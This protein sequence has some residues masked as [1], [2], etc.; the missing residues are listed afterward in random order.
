MIGIYIY[1]TSKVLFFLGYLYV[2]E[3]SKIIYVVYL[4]VRL[5][6]NK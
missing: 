1:I 2:F 6:R 4:V 3:I 5:R